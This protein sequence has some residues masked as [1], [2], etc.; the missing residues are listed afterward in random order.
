MFGPQCK[1]VRNIREF[2]LTG[3]SR[4]HLSH[5]FTLNQVSK[6]DAINTCS[7]EEKCY[8]NREKLL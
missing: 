2:S 3:G 4:I 7:E 6:H 8:D 1:Y 5:S